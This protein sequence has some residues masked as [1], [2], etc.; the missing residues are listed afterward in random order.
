M[1][2]LFPSASLSLHPAGRNIRCC[3]SCQPRSYPCSFISDVRSVV[4]IAIDSQLIYWTSHRMIDLLQVFHQ[5]W[6]DRVLAIYLRLT[7]TCNRV[8]VVNYEILSTRTVRVLVWF[9]PFILNY[10]VVWRWYRIIRVLGT[11][12]VLEC[13]WS[14]RRTM[15]VSATR[16]TIKVTV[17][18]TNTPTKNWHFSGNSMFAIIWIHR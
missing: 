2:H 4:F 6:N 15:N 1:L 5:Y 17:V 12:V 10:R 3:T 11:N 7:C 18:R 9:N 14:M 16:R 8:I 13:A